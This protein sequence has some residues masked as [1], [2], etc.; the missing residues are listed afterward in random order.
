ME[1]RF[2]GRGTEL[3]VLTSEFERARATEARVVL[4]EGLPGIGKSA[5][6]R[7]FLAAAPSA[8]V[9]HADCDEGETQLA[10][11]SC[12]PG[13]DAG[14]VRAAKPHDYGRGQLRT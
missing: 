7:R 10:S 2:V 1:D 13:K 5:L 14:R 9:L 12:V 3:D 4:V 11:L 8:L 6:V